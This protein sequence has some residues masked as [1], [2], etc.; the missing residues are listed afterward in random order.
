MRKAA[1]LFAA[2]FLTAAAARAD[3]I[4]LRSG[5]RL[6]VTGYERAGD[7]YRLAIEGGTVE[8]PAANVVAIEREEVFSRVPP[9]PPPGPFSREIHA[10]AKKHGLDEAL[11]SS[12][13]AAES[14]YNPRAVS[15]KRAL[16]L[17][18][19]LPTT[20]AR[21][22]VS[23]AF[24]PAQNVDAGT[25]YLRQ[26][27]DLYHGDL[28]L[29]L[30]AYNAGPERVEQYGGVPPYNETRAYLQRVAR[31][32]AERKKADAAKPPL[33]CVSLAFPCEDSAAP[34]LHTK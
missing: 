16:G 18:Q 6:H 26:L 15:R 9:E 1:L 12:V 21:F 20:A 7:V 34:L 32:L 33:P 4:V 13:I 28:T 31:K 11:I 10:A 25:Q 17:M 8:V 14:N 27:L 30:A 24:D 19:L 29:A 3:Y 23:N 22:S 5:Q 2:I